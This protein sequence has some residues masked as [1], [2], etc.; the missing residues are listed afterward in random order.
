[1]TDFEG[2][3]PAL[4]AAL[5]KRNYETL[6]PVQQE[7]LA[8]ELRDADMLVSAQTGSGKT[9]AFGLAL[10]PTLLGEAERFHHTKAPR[11]LVVAPTRE[12]ALQVKRELEWLYAETGA[13]FAS[14]VGGM[15]MRTE[16]QVLGRGVHI[17]V[18]TPGR[19]RDHI[20][21][22][23]LDMRSLQAVVLDEA[24]EML[25][26]GFRE[27]LE[28]ILDSAPAERRTLMFSATVPRMIANL[29]KKY[30]NDA[31]RVKTAAEQQQH[32]DI[33]YRALNVA[34]HERENA[35][36]NVLRYYEAKSAIVFCA[37]RMGVNRMTSRFTNR[38]FSV[39]ALSGELSQG[40]RTH[41]LQAMRDGR[42]R[43]CI[44]TDVAAR[45]LDLPNLE[46]VIH[47]DLPEN[48]QALLHRS[49]R[50]GRAGRK[51]T[52][53]L[54]VPH[55]RRKRTERLFYDA[56]IEAEWANPP[57]VDDVTERDDA[58]LLEDPVLVDAI[59]DEEKAFVGEIL[60][61]H[62]PEQVAAAFVRQYRAGQSAPEDLNDAPPPRGRDER[63][64]AGRGEKRA[65]RDDFKDG[66]WFSLSVGH[67]ET[68]EPRWLVP[69]LYRAGNIAKGG[70]GAIKI[71]NS[72]SH[73]EIEPGSVDKFLEAL[74]PDGVIE[75]GI[76]VKRL[77]GPP[78]E[79]REKRESYIKKKRRDDKGAGPRGRSD[80]NDRP[81]RGGKPR[82]PSAEA[83][84][85]SGDDK[86][87]E[88]PG[89]EK[90]RSARPAADRPRPKRADDSDVDTRPRPGKRD[91]E[92][93]G[94]KES[95]PRADTGREN[96]GENRG[97]NRAEGYRGRPGMP[98]R[99]DG[100]ARPAHGKS[101]GKPKGKNPGK[102]ARK[103]RAEAAAEERGERPEGG[104]AP[105]AT[106]KSKKGYKP[107]KSNFRKK[108][109][110]PRGGASD[111]FSPRK[112]RT[113]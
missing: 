34:N 12:L 63:G 20:E 64:P 51:G 75:K 25:D 102:Y 22:R 23:S 46:L 97:E 28:F 31:V 43:V 88:K 7:V 65:P 57:S 93:P 78:P 74:G 95:K 4:G 58:R 83:P 86:P 13:A 56:R 8:P 98:A 76:R 5:T 92:K 14:C 101:H 1:M 19:L 82:G 105:R 90:P 42:A 73:V 38:G 24:D 66:V 16:R 55:N 110:K 107:G 60:A 45:G 3:V 40:Q 80:R 47:A 99:P 100:D 94:A 85:Y 26:L 113:T 18:G 39:V 52:S 35:I 109:G 21:R 68:A 61:R 87:W 11:A 48:S 41:A 54:I 59:R 104:A 30:Q 6:T 10:A 44:A 36:I 103:A 15:D 79:I 84:S 49:G 32:V 70:I 33:E 112:R 29:A 106:L 53:V 71:Y 91:W 9:V 17:V 27:D 37:T 72:E 2:V 111:G 50:T 81:D 108:G 89:A 96:R 69:M 62:S 67:K 77:D